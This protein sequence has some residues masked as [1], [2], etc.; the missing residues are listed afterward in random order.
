MALCLLPFGVLLGFGV[1]RRRRSAGMLAGLLAMLALA[2]SVGVTGCGSLDVNGTPAG[3]YTF[4]V[5]AIGTN[6]STTQSA[7]MAL[8]VTQ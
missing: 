8:K 1:Y 5:T 4:Q 3:A 2:I 7:P 6:T